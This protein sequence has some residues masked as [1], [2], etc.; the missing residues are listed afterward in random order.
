MTVQYEGV[1]FKEQGGLHLLSHQHTEIIIPLISDG[2][3][4]GTV[5]VT[6]QTK[7]YLQREDLVHSSRRP[8]FFSLL[9]TCPCWA[10]DEKACSFAFRSEGNTSS[11]LA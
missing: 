2:A 9:Y 4:T 8:S 3:E 11:F 6:A 10:L 1:V 5:D 7:V